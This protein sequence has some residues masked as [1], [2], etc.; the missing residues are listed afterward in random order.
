[1]RQKMLYAS[2]KATLKQEFGGGQ[3]RDDLYGNVKEDITLDGYKKHL[4]S[5]A[6]PGPLSREEMERE[7]V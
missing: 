2:T 1:M 4:M 6:A 7:E 5:A 3:I